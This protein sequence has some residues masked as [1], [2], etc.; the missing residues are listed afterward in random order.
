MND[1]CVL[2]ILF[3]LF[4]FFCISKSFFFQELK[5]SKSVVGLLIFTENLFLTKPSNTRY[6][7]WILILFECIIILFKSNSF[8]FFMFIV[9]CVVEEV[10]HS[11]GPSPFY[12]FS[13]LFRIKTLIIFIKYLVININLKNLPPKYSIISFLYYLKHNLE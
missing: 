12:S 6:S 4:F 2:H 7:S 3:N 13:V 1:Y 5:W 10:K 9:I 11:S 8:C